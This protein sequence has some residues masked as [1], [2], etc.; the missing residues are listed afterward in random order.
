MRS[1]TL[2]HGRDDEASVVVRIGRLPS[3]G[4]DPQA[5]VR[6]V[7]GA[8]PSSAGAACDEVSTLS[9]VECTEI[10]YGV[11]SG[12]GSA[13]TSTSRTA[14]AAG[15]PFAAFNSPSMVRTRNSTMRGLRTSR[16]AISGS[17]QRGQRRARTS[18]SRRVSSR[19]SVVPE[20][21]WR[22]GAVRSRLITATV[23]WALPW[24]VEPR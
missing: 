7:P 24:E 16:S 18:R 13:Q 23:G 2:G 3:S 14:M 10:M 4:G 11:L 1:V 5:L 21:D 17:L 15:C 20:D 12:V 6:P 19:L 22:E 8:G 9:S